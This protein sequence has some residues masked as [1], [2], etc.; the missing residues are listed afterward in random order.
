M[1]SSRVTNIAI[2]PCEKRRT[3]DNTMHFVVPAERVGKVSTDVATSKKLESANTMYD[4]NA[5]NCVAWTRGLEFAGII[6][7]NI[8]LPG[9]SMSFMSFHLG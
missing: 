5:K 4:N 6:D 3:Q 8:S 1:I 7:A 2:N 9:L